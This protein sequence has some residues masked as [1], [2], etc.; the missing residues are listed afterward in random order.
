MAATPPRSQQMQEAPNE[1]VEAEEFTSIA[2]ATG[3]NIYTLPK[4]A[5]SL[6]RVVIQYKT[7]TALQNAVVPGTQ[8]FRLVDADPIPTST[9]DIT[10]RSSTTVYTGFA[11]VYEQ[12][13]WEDSAGTLATLEWDGSGDEP[14]NSTPIKIEYS[15]NTKL[16]GVEL[17]EDSESIDLNVDNHSI[18]YGTD[19]AIIYR[20][21][22]RKLLRNDN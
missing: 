22:V 1:P 10:V 11:V 14:P 12:Q 9:S 7:S 5:S 20:T 3:V 18:I 6:D 8:S 15:A 13:I 19:M 4:V 17:T 16:N 2:Y 21:A